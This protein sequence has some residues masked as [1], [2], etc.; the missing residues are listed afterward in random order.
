M[1]ACCAYI[2]GLL[3]TKKSYYFLKCIQKIFFYK[4]NK[5]LRNI[6]CC[7][8]ILKSKLILFWLNTPFNI[9]KAWYFL[10][11]YFCEKFHC[12]VCDKMN[13]FEAGLNSVVV[14]VIRHDLFRGQASPTQIRGH[15]NLVGASSILYF[16]FIFNYYWEILFVVNIIFILSEDCTKED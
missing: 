9:L 5:V 8:Y 3:Y 1:I 2:L 11:W 10:V 4:I 15:H 14:C 12:D 6:F 13:V 16:L 7:K